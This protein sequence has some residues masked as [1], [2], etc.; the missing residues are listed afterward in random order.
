M[1]RLPPVP[2]MNRIGNKRDFV[3]SGTELMI[4]KMS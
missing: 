1:G 2:V 4:I 3:R